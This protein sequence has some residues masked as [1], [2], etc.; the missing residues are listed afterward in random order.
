M[1]KWKKKSTLKL[2]L[3]LIEM[4][5]HLFSCMRPHVFLQVVVVNEGV[6]ADFTDLPACLQAS[7]GLHVVVSGAAS[8]EPLVAYFADENSL[9]YMSAHV[10]F[11]LIF[12]CKKLPNFCH[13]VP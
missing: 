10:N 8:I 12:S 11:Q 4:K 2:T 7:V 3:S 1:A 5:C 13:L 9:I 6:V